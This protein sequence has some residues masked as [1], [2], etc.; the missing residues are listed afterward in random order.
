M[1]TNKE[2]KG[3]LKKVIEEFFECLNYRDVSYI[4][5]KGEMI[6]LTGGMSWG[7]YPTDSCNVFN[8]FICLPQKILTAGGLKWD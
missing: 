8:R 2:I 3:H 1:L 6:Y 5:H 7:D 4:E